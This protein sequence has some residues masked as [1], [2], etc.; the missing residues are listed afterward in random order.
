MVNSVACQI[1]NQVSDY[2]QCEYSCEYVEIWTVRCDADYRDV[3][4]TGRLIPTNV[5]RGTDLMKA[6]GQWL[7]TGRSSITVNNEQITV[8]KQCDLAI[9][10]PYAADCTTGNT[11]RSTGSLGGGDGDDDDDDDDNS[12][13]AIVGGL[14][15]GLLIIC[16]TIIVLVLIFQVFKRKQQK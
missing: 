1:A 3:I 11:G 15:A 8:D 16:I 10:Y 9:D 14:I 2:C 6:M 13:G 5:Q 7:E 12:T 4:L